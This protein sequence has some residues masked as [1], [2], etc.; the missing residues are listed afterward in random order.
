MFHI[1]VEIRIHGYES[2]YSLRRFCSFKGKKYILRNII[3][4]FIKIIIVL[5]F[6]I[7]IS[8]GENLYRIID[9]QN[10]RDSKTFLSPKRRREK[11][12]EKI[13]TRFS[14]PR[15]KDRY[16]T[17]TYCAGG[18]TPCK[19]C[20]PGC[21]AARIKSR[22]RRCFI[23]YAVAQSRLCQREYGIGGAVTVAAGV[24][25]TR[26]KK[27]AHSSGSTLHFS[28]RPEKGEPPRRALRPAFMPD[29]SV[30]HGHCPYD[31]QRAYSHTRVHTRNGGTPLEIV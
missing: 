4:R 18:Q 5:N 8:R 14:K 26:E 17:A 21:E 28:R 9:V 20:H 13:S 10:N 24:I 2:F 23:V 30:S 12:R 22:T 16:I 29:E 19:E 31:S 7:K 1:N 15:S 3:I 27:E 6:E 25:G 11:K